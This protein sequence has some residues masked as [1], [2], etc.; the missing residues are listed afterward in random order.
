M[1]GET[2][3]IGKGNPVQAMTDPEGSRKLRFSEFLE[4]RHMNVAGLSALRSGHLYSPRR[5]A[6]YSFLL[7]PE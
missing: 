1:H 2:M 6:W 7:E 3:E 5:Y 4:T